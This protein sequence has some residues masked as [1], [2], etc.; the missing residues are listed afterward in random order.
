MFSWFCAA[1]AAQN[2]IEKFLPARG[3]SRCFIS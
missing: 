3:N 1:G 2:Y